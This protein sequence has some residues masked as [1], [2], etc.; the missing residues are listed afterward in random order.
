MRSRRLAVGFAAVITFGLGTLATRAGI[1][2]PT[3]L[4][5]YPGSTITRGQMSCGTSRRN[6]PERR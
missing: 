2:T 4:A 5:K 1:P 6:S 3:P